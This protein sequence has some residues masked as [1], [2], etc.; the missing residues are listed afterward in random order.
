MQCRL[1]VENKQSNRNKSNDYFESLRYRQDERHI[2][3]YHNRKKTSLTIRVAQKITVIRA[4][5][6]G[7]FAV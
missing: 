6:I 3:H 7:K 4:Q 5:K 2:A 1:Q